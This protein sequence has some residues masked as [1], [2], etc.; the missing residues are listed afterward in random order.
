MRVKKIIFCSLIIAPL[1]GCDKVEMPIG[2]PAQ[3]IDTIPDTTSVPDTVQY[4]K[5]LVEEF[6]GHQCT[7]CPANTEQLIALQEEYPDQVIVVSYHAGFFATVAP[8]DYPTNFQTQ[9]GNDFYEDIGPLN[10]FPAALVNR[11]EYEEFSNAKFFYQHGQWKNPILNSL[12][13]ETSLAI[14]LQANLIS[15]GSSFEV[16]VKVNS[17]TP[18]SGAHRL[19]L[20]C[21]EDHVVAPQKDGR[22][23]INVYPHQIDTAYVHRHVLRGQINGA[24]GVYGEPIGTTGEPDLAYTN[25]Y[26]VPV[27][28]NV[29][30]AENCSIVAFVIEEASG[31]VVQAQ[32]VHVHVV[33]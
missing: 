21:V 22:L 33:E 9:Y 11:K 5:I 8:P 20:L 18:L 12:N 25:T 29:V 1:I 32:E 2:P 16:D 4:R 23:D 3:V 17:P 27:A 31:E 15:G 7:G 28:A 14:D 24:Q 19:V 13:H 30:T 26:T 6:T 10:T